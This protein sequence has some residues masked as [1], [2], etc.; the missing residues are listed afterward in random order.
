MLLTRNV[1]SPR[2]LHLE[3]TERGEF[4]GPGVVLFHSSAD[5]SSSGVSWIISYYFLHTKTPNESKTTYFCHPQTSRPL[6]RIIWRRSEAG[7]CLWIEWRLRMAPMQQEKV[8]SV[9]QEESV[10]G[11]ANHDGYGWSEGIGWWLRMWGRG[12]RQRK[13]CILAA[14]WGTAS[15]RWG[16]GDGHGRGA[17]IKKWRRD[18]AVRASCFL[19]FLLGSSS[20]CDVDF[21]KNA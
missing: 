3:S 11:G 21:E 1:P 14:G 17:V 4:G 8:V 19:H 2:H 18:K 5:E 20:S 10:C 15:E 7:G 9:P 6:L 13:V 12:R 16:V